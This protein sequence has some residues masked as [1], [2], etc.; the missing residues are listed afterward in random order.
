MLLNHGNPFT[1]I[2]VQTGWARLFSSIHQNHPTHMCYRV[3][4]LIDIANFLLEWNRSKTIKEK[5][6]KHQ[7][8]L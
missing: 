5:K 8:H 4:V 7:K 3:Q 1:N 6:K 2:V